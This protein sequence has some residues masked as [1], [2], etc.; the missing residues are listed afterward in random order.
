MLKNMLNTSKTLILLSM[1]ITFGSFMHILDAMIA[2]GHIINNVENFLRTFIEFLIICNICE[3]NI[4]LLTNNNKFMNEYDGFIV[5][6][7][8]F[9]LRLFYNLVPHAFYC[10][11]FVNSV[12]I[13]LSL[14]MLMILVIHI[15][16]ICMKKIYRSMLIYLK[17]I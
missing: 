7:G 2:T 8:S 13:F 10:V 11:K 16:N 4:V 14:F 6:I 1:M 5:S 17:L 12:I 3:F 9:I 15:E